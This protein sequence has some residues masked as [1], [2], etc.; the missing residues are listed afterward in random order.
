M[1]TMSLRRL[2]NVGISGFTMSILAAALLASQGCIKVRHAALPIARIEGL[3]RP[4]F[5]GQI[6]DIKEQKTITYTTLLEKLAAAN[7]VFLG[8]VHNNPDHH[9][10][11]IQILQSLSH[12][13]G[14][15]TLAVEFL[16]A[17]IQPLI[18]KYLDG[19]IPEGEFL[20]K[21]DWHETWGFDYHFYRP[22]IDFQ[23]YSGNPLA[24]IN[25]P[26]DVVRKVAAK[27]LK[28]LSQRERLLIAQDID[29]TDN[30]HRALLKE[31]YKSHSHDLLKNFEYFYE[32]QCVWDETMAQNLA[33]LIKDTH[34]KIVVICGNGHLVYGLGIPKRLMRRIKTSMVTLL[35]YTLKQTTLIKRNLA[36]F[37]WFT[38]EY[39][40]IS[41]SHPTTKSGAEIGFDKKARID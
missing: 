12:I 10:I 25:A 20:K 2:F 36:D 32:A 22:L 34:T 23:R 27:G 33:T 38:G 9:L 35:P 5:P 13:W 21:I 19:Q 11:Q 6:L 24:A 1:D 26:R 14:H 37:V 29:L 15:Y 30:R 4:F 39:F 40:R 31:I 3:K 7:V 17:Q 41:E 16:P 18:D 28:S 8:E